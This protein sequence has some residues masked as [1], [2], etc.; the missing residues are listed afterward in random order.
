MAQPSF[1]VGSRSGISTLV[2]SAEVLAGKHGMETYV[3]AGVLLRG[4]G[5]GL[6]SF[7]HI[8]TVIR[9]YLAQSRI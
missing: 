9:L 8:A 1:G 3:V 4:E 6:E 2:S 5:Q 7:P